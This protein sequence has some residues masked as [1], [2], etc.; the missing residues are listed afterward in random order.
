[1][2][3]KI[4]V[5]GSAGFIGFHLISSL[6]KLKI[7]L[8]G[9][10]SVNSYYDVN[11]K[12]DRLRQHG[13]TII[14]AEN[15]AAKSDDFEN[16]VTPIISKTF[17]QYKFYKAHINNIASV[18]A[19]FKFE[20]PEIV[21]N[22]AA[23]P[24]VRHSLSFP[25]EYLTSNI[26]GFLNILENC[27][28]YKIKHLLYA[29]SSSVYGLNT[30]LPFKTCEG[31]D[32]PISL[33]GATKKSNELMA[34]CYSHLFD[35][36]TTGLRFFTVYGP[37]GRPDMALYS[38][39]KSILNGI[40]IDL[41]NNGDM[42]R[43]FTYVDDIVHSILQLIDKIPSRSFDKNLLNNPNSSTAPYRILNIGN[44]NPIILRDF[45][46]VLEEAIGQEAIINYKETQPGDVYA[47]QADI[48]D[49]IDLIDYKPTTS[50]KEGVTSF[51]SWYKEYYS[52]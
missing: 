44:N 35:V 31:A 19:I 32:H 2:Y 38:F 30:E 21:I 15:D 50:V 39:T 27:R 34:H 16:E 26:D 9:I 52:N 46:K 6:L 47:T 28:S 13:I 25:R 29:S 20:K 45:L 40:P 37:W 49:L 36:P 48:A 17:P 12:L 11:L 10:D 7:D 43:D 33:Y 18:E 8:V 4:L 14:N 22:L 51:V 41:F 5:T 24:G 1:M 23:Q 3:K 42:I